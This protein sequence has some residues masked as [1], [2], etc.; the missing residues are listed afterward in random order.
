M[1]LTL[2]SRVQRAAE[3]ALRGKR[4]ACVVLDPRSGAVLA[5][6]SNPSYD[7][8][9]VDDD[10]DEISSADEGAALLD[11]GRQALYP[12]GSTFKIVTL[13]GALGAGTATLS[14]TFPGPGTLE[15]G[16]APVTNFEGG[17]YSDIGLLDATARSVNT[18]FAR[19][20]VDLGPEK[21]VEQADRF[22]FDSEVDYELPA[23]VSL[24]P[25]PAEMTTW[26]T[27]WAGVGQPVGEHDSP[28][29]PQ[30]TV[31]QMALVA[32]GVAN[33]GAVMRPYVLDSVLDTSGRP[34][35]ATITIPRRL[36]TATDPATA[37]EVTRA[38]VRVVEAGSGAGARISGAAVAGKTGTAEVGR[39]KAT[40]A[41]FIAFAPADNPTVAL[42]IMLEGGGLGGRVAAPA[43]R[44]VL[45]AALKAQTEK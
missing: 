3:K 16:G 27:A 12:P 41:W 7:P 5:S 28:A 44:S 8:A 25:D 29:G 21:L 35:P 13:T 32:S 31:M 24:M 19:L 33:D 23:K 1:R 11:R 36:T 17:S 34:S 9:S 15:I 40:N 14:D 26:E 20:A 4:G 45:Q 43:A 42:A 37:E 22:G 30:A 38:M 18:V 2:D 6:A 10:W 39:G